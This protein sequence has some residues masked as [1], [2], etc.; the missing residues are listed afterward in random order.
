M[1][2][3]SD[4][5]G[6]WDSDEEYWGSNPNDAN[7]TPEHGYLPET[8]SDGVDNDADGA[9]DMSD[10]GCRVDSDG[11]GWADLADN[12]PWDTNALQA[13]RDGDGVGDACDYDADNDG[14]DDET[15]RQA[16]SDPNNENST[17]EVAAIGFCDDGIDNDAD[18]MTDA[19][20]PGCAPDQ[21]YD[22]VADATDNCPTMWNQD[23]ADGDHDGTGDACEDS[24]GDGFFDIDEGYL[25]SDAHNPSSTPEYSWFEGAC[26]DGVDNDHDGTTDGAD[27][28]CQVIFET[29]PGEDGTAYLPMSARDTYDGRL[30][31]SNQNVQPI[32]LPA[33][34]DGPADSENNVAL[35]VALASAA[36][37]AGSGLAF[38]GLR[39]AKRTAH[40]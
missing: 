33:A 5:D 19:A 15:E 25:G 35:I 6:Y 24:D 27:E 30:Y 23:Q 37:V 17:P 16:S 18:G 28:G 14:W 36:A 9:I 11:D 1:P 2:D 22:Y 39:I 20:D 8:C 31:K 21:D 4:N 26:T 29:A 34:G 12:C 7:S 13:D 40:R 32:A 38:A 3:D 10:S